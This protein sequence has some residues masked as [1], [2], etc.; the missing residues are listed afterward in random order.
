MVLTKCAARGPAT[1]HLRYPPEQPQEPTMTTDGLTI[2]PYI[3]TVTGN[4][5][6]W[7]ILRDSAVVYDGI[8]TDVDAEH[9]LNSYAKTG[10][11]EYR[12]AP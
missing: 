2:R 12:P 9:L 3:N 4:I 7:Q 6:C 8:A 1:E 5:Y 10:R 11:F